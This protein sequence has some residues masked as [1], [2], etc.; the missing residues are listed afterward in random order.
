MAITAE[1]AKER[2]EKLSVEE[3][4]AEY[5]DLKKNYCFNSKEEQIDYEIKNYLFT[6]SNDE[7]K[8]IALEEL[9]KEKTGK[10]YKIEEKWFD[11]TLPDVIDYLAKP[12]K[13]PF[14]NIT[15]TNFFNKLNNIDDEEKID[16]LF[17]LVQDKNTFDDF[18]RNIVKTNNAI[19]TYKEYKK[20][21]HEY[22]LSHMIIC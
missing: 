5:A 18:T 7:E 3:L 14:W 4:E 16:F 10:E 21:S 17:E 9:L 6:E 1:I 15:F 13:D 12:D 11:I 22:F 19:E 2:Y 20:K 8:R